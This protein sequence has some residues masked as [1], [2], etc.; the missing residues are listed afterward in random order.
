MLYPGF[1]EYGIFCLMLM[2]YNE[3]CENRFDKI[4]KPHPHKQ[5]FNLLRLA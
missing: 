4:R 1:Y 5:F 2:E 3:D